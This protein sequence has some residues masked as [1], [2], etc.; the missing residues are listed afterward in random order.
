[1]ARLADI[2][3]SSDD[4]LPDLKTLIRKQGARATRTASKP[5]SVST[6]PAASN[7]TA[8]SE[9]RRVRR[10]GEPSKATGNPL[11]QRWNSEEHENSQE[12][13]SRGP[14]RASRKT[15]PSESISPPPETGSASDSE[16]EDD[17]PRAN[18]QRPRRRQPAIEDSDEDSDS[19]GEETLITRVRRLQKT[20]AGAVRASSQETEKRVPRARL[21]SKSKALMFARE[22]ESGTDT[23][24][25]REESEAEDPSVYQTAGEDSS[26]SASE[27]DWLN[28]SPDQPARTK[29][30]R[31][32]KVRPQGTAGAKDNA[33]LIRNAP[34]LKPKARTSQNNTKETASSKEVAQSRKTSQSKQRGDSQDTTTASDLADTLSKLRLQLQD[35]SDEEGKS[36]KRD[37][38]TTPPS[39]P[40]K[41]SKPKGLISPSKKVQIPK[42]PP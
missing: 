20:K 35:F 37:Q 7:P 4:D 6:K 21:E 8:K 23:E 10:L 14:G 27:L 2:C 9:T 17:L 26:D 22:I 11:F 36:S 24:V 31:P 18:V 34:S 15:T 16:S 19:Q 28:D 25:N 12:G 30:T 39:T 32:V 40:P 42:T 33:S 29:P 3:P 13:R 38:F 1:M 5:T 41:A